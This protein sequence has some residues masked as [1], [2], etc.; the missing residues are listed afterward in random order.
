M[1]AVG[2]GGMGAVLLA[3]ST[4]D[5]LW[6]IGLFVGT[7]ATVFLA[8]VVKHVLRVRRQRNRD[9][10]EAQSMSEEGY[11]PGPPVEPVDE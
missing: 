5:V 4:A 2:V 9:R 8:L 3:A 1:G 11:P 6:S 10:T 7:P